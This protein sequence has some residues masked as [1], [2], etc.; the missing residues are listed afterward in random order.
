MLAKLP[1][2][3]LTLFSYAHCKNAIVFH[4]K[5]LPSKVPSHSLNRR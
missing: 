1:L 2:V 3:I 5:Y 4:I